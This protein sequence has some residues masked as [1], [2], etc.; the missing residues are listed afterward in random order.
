MPFSE[1]DA[2]YL[3]EHTQKRFLQISSLISS[4][5]FTGF[6]LIF[7]SFSLS[8][9]FYKSPA[10]MITPHTQREEHSVTR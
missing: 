4:A 1:N 9:A 5:R 8:A 10:D 3:C 2:H 7:H 6:S